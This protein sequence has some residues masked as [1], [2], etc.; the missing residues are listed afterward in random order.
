[1][2][3]YLLKKNKESLQNKMTKINMTDDNIET[4]I[5]LIIE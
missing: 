3:Y 4:L 2:I 5:S 1:M